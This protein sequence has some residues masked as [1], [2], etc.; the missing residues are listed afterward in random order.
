MFTHTALTKPS[1]DDVYN[2]NDGVKMRL[3]IGMFTK[4]LF[5]NED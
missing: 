1:Y 4:C 3:P 5:N 2:T